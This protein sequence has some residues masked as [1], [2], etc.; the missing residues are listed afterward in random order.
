MFGFVFPN[1]EAA[2]RNES[3]H[4]GNNMEKSDAEDFFVDGNVL[5]QDLGPEVNA[6]L[7]ELFDEDVIFV[8]C[9]CCVLFS[10][11]DYFYFR[12]RTR[13]MWL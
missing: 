9:L 8:A 1:R 10:K 12:M 7:T 2:E 5:M 3:P 6:A 4:D 11:C 13:K